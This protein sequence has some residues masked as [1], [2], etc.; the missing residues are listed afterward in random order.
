MKKIL[1]L[2]LMLIAG[3]ASAQQTV[4]TDSGDGIFYYDSSFQKVFLTSFS[5]SG[6]VSEFVLTP[7]DSSRTWSSAASS[8]DGSIL[9]SVA[10]GGQIYTSTDS[11]TNWTARESNRTWTGV[12]VS[13]NG[14]IMAACWV[15][16][17]GIHTSW[18]GGTNWTS[19]GIVKNWSSVDTSYDGS[20]MAATA[21]GGQIYTSTDSGTNW[22]ARDSNRNWRD[23]AVSADGS[24]MA[25]CGQNIQIYTSTDTGTTWTVRSSSNTLWRSICSSAD[26]QRLAA[27]SQSG[28]IHVSTD[29]GTNWTQKAWYGGWWSLGCS[30][31]GLTI[32]AGQ[33][34][35][36]IY[37]STDGG[38]NWLRAVL[39]PL[40]KGWLGIDSSADGSNIVAAAY[41]TNV[42]VGS[43]VTTNLDANV[44]YLDQYNVFA[45]SNRFNGDI[46][47]G[48]GVYYD[49]S[50]G[51]WRQVGS[52]DNLYDMTS[53]YLYGNTSG[54]GIDV[55]LSTLDNSAISG[56]LVGETVLDWK[57]LYLDGPWLSYSEAT[58][59]YEIV[60]WQTMTNHLA[61]GI[62]YDV[63]LGMVLNSGGNDSIDCS[64]GITYGPGDNS[65][66]NWRIRYLLGVGAPATP[67]RSGG[68]ADSGDE[69]V[70]WTCMTNYCF[71][72]SVTNT[73]ISGPSDSVTNVQVFLDGQLR[74]WTTNGVALP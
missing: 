40:N 18:D 32:Y 28:Y 59:G 44:A 55:Y 24:L 9:A 19:T 45:E 60:N 73:W 56:L 1:I 38:D 6:T 33:N 16:S 26:G 47:L 7:R 53:R 37:K 11:G 41:N 27:C 63:T 14:Q 69:I 10:Q 5:D 34:T 54:E 51:V 35:G 58:N 13:S 52:D 50:D 12:C 66:M 36:E 17:G 64:A 74:S 57:N 42:Y 3:S 4:F 65:T 22:T 8:F 2:M 62:D 70:N 29:A 71:G 72:L 46:Q 48:G 25:A 39:E 31:D 49:V 15:S 20:I 21:Y 43:Y 23:V 61:Q 30:A 67:W 68:I